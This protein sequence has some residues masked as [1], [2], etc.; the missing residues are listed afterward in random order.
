LQL[1][2]RRPWSGEVCI[3]AD[4]SILDRPV[5]PAALVGAVASLL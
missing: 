3:G 2:A 1:R 4:M 5:T